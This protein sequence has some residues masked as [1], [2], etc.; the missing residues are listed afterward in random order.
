MGDYTAENPLTWYSF[1]IAGWPK[2]DQFI[3]YQY[4]LAGAQPIHMIWTDTPCWTTCWNGGNEM[5]RALCSPQIECVV[6]QHPWFENDC[7]FADIILPVN[8]RFEVRDISSDG[9]NGNHAL[10][11]FEDKCVEPVGESM[12]DYE[13]VGEVAKKLGLY[14]AYTQNKTVDDWIRLAFE[15]SGAEKYI[16]YAEFT[17][18]GYFASPTVENWEE[19]AVNGFEPFYRDPEANPLDTPTGKLEFYSESLAEGFPDDV[20]RGPYPRFL[21]Y[22]ESHQ[23][24]LLHPRSEKFPYLIV[25]NHPRWRVHAQ[26]DDITWLREIETCKVTGPDGYQYEPV[27]IHPDDAAKKSVKHGD[28]VKVFNDRGWVLGGAYV[29]ERIIPGAIYQDHGARLDPIENGVSDRSG[30][31]NLICP[32]NTTSKNC[33]GEVTSGFLVDFE[34]VDVFQL[35][36]EYPEAFSR[37]YDDGVGVSIDNFIDFA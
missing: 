32:S 1:P 9:E 27:W 11:V 34:A 33:P 23:E 18:K 8:T 31:N 36:K 10:L 20:E 21:P 4:P 16:T 7:R 5:I 13:A 17:E 19:V 3:E 6:A 22:G 12:S 29:T 25:S 26:M 30:A 28:I 24:S 37:K 15:N 2:E 35:A 14:E